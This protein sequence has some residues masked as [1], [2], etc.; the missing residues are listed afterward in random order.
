MS[1]RI[2]SL[3]KKCLVLWLIPL[4]ILPMATADSVFGIEPEIKG[5]LKGFS[6]EYIL[7]NTSDWTTAMVD[8]EN[9]NLLLSQETITIPGTRYSLYVELTYNS[10][11]STVNSPF[12]LGWS[13]VLSERI[14]SVPNSTQKKYIDATG[15]EWEFNWNETI[16][17]YDIPNS[18]Q[19][20]LA[21]MIDGSC[22]ITTPDQKERRF[23]SEGKLSGWRECGTEM[24]TFQYDE[25]NRLTTILDI[26][27][28]RRLTIQYTAEGKVSSIT[29][30]MNQSW[31][32]T[33]N[34]EKTLLISI[35]RPDS[36]SM[37]LEYTA[38]VMTTFS[39]FDENEYEVTYYTGE[40]PVK[41]NTISLSESHV[42]TFAYSNIDL[43]SKKTTLTD[44]NNASTEFVF[45][46]SNRHLTEVST[47]VNSILHKTEFTYNLQGMIETIIDSSGHVMTY[48]YNAF[49]LL[50][51]ATFP[52]E[53]GTEAYVIEK[54]YDP[55][56]NLLLTKREKINST[57][58]W[59]ITQYQYSDVN[60]PCLPSQVI[61]P[62][63]T[64]T[65]YDYDEH[66]LLTSITSG[67]GPYSEDQF[68]TT[69]Y[70]YQSNGNRA[71]KADPEGNE[72][73]YQYNGNG[74]NVASTSFQG[75]SDI[76]QPVS[77]I[78]FAYDSNNRMISQSD[79]MNNQSIT[80][81]YDT[82][83]FQ[84]SLMRSSG[85][86]S[87][88]TI[89]MS[90]VMILRPIVDFRNLST[91]QALSI[92]YSLNDFVSLNG[93]I[94][95][96]SIKSSLTEYTPLIASSTDSLQHTTQFSYNLRGDLVQEQN[97]LGQQN[98]YQVDSLGRVTSFT[99][100][101]NHSVSYQYD[102]NSRI[103][104]MNDSL[105]GM[106]TFFYNAIGDLTSTQDPILGNI[107][108]Q[109]NLKGN[110]LSDQKGFYS[111]D[112]LGRRTASYYYS[113]QT[114]QWV[115][116]RDG[117]ILAKNGIAKPRN[118]L[119]QILS[120][121][122]ETGGS[123]AINVEESTG[124]IEN[125]TGSGDIA[126]MQFSYLN[127]QWLSQLTDMQK[128]LSFQY[129]WTSYGYL[130]AQ[131]FPNQVETS[132]TD[133][134]K[135][136]DKVVTKL[137]SE[138]Y[139]QSDPS[140]NQEDKISSESDS[141]TIGG[142]SLTYSSTINRDSN[143]L[144]QS[145][146]Y[147]DNQS[148]QYGYQSNSPLIN[149]VQI[150][151]DGT[152]EITRNTQNRIHQIAYPNAMTET[153]NYQDSLKHLTNIQY[154]N[155]NSLSF[156][157]NNQDKMT[158]IAGIENSQLVVMS[159]TYDGEGRI[160]QL[161]KSIQGMEAEIWTFSYHPTGIDKAV[162]TTYGIPTLSLDFTT[163]LYGKILSATYSELNGYQGELYYHSNALGN[164]S[165][166]TNQQ[167]IPVAGWTY[168]LHNG[169]IA[170]SYN[171]MNILPL[172]GFQ[173]E[174]QWM[175]FPL[176]GS[177]PSLLLNLN[178]AAKLSNQYGFLGI[179]SIELH[180]TYSFGLTNNGSNAGTCAEDCLSKG[181]SPCCV[182]YK[183]SEE[184]Q[185]NCDERAA[186]DNK[187]SPGGVSAEDCINNCTSQCVK[188]GCCDKGKS[189]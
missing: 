149:S 139:L 152:Y 122:N 186:R 189:S 28:Q 183:S 37:S 16:S 117:Y 133:T 188:Q 184:C 10:L 31:T 25:Q 9:G 120:F 38:N 108:Y 127:H 50:T 94:T 75:D 154:S 73:T 56:T 130:N 67:T 53:T 102:A 147:G 51:R 98:N 88:Q 110:L 99:D 153:Y 13:S 68:K 92:Q 172:F 47:T 39:D 159:L 52:H 81:S 146:Q 69:S 33:Y 26:L 55:V 11:F 124:L 54:A 103:T 32:F 57:P 156:T 17:R 144:I 30:S 59:A 64:V 162:R 78:N 89:A 82:N 115:Y 155:G 58:T 97:Y 15:A 176:F 46:K 83:G 128:Q 87:S 161:T 106:T 173:A 143:N 169:Q 150:T 21:Q 60:A 48:E 77:L 3:M 91:C 34:T 101:T 121:E 43:T 66:H 8:L 145:I 95:A 24:V 141:L 178:G 158:Q 45:Q 35:T 131:N 107:S 148:I 132:L 164:T 168:K 5:G 22:S 135:L 180:V 20:Q 116:S 23:D 41:V 96:G 29:D 166:L 142:Q 187:E 42:Y 19:Y 125:W 129:A 40:N 181:K 118:L 100:F 109:H 63:G 136:L 138:V 182:E 49:H 93:A 74:F 179:Q 18:T 163:D 80:M 6:F 177:G 111:V 171:P 112:L 140:Y 12:G 119:G 126:S 76:N 90:S 44:P 185:R 104:S 27:S 113:G 167:G 114:D 36:H 170:Q 174:Q 70:Q 62:L 7:V 72:T 4:L 165:L 134:N 137:G 14:L 61:D 86:S 2:V 71:S 79:S 151:G 65:N 1:K 105:Q 85:C 157:W 160:R 175:T 123:A 84:V